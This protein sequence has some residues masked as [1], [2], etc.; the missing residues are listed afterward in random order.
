LLY[1]YFFTHLVIQKW[2]NLHFKSFKY[3]FGTYNPRCI[4]TKGSSGCLKHCYGGCP[5]RWNSQ[6]L[7]KTQHA[8]TK[9]RICQHFNWKIWK[10][11]TNSL[12]VKCLFN[13][14]FVLVYKRIKTLHIAKSWICWFEILQQIGAARI[15][16]IPN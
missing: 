9:L 16:G 3:K 5:S 8:I 7:Y 1:T 13:Y 4:S 10:S 12:K 11:S 6:K 15:C 2:Q 14:N